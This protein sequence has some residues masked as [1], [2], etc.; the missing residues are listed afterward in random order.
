[1]SERRARL[2]FKE[3]FDICE[4]SLKPNFDKDEIMKRYGIGKSCLYNTLKQK[5]SIL[6]MNSSKNNANFK[7]FNT[8]K[9]DELETKLTHCKK[10]R[11]IS[12]K[13]KIYV[14]IP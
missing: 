8:S 14:H 6:K 13:K 11:H 1:M 4:L 9:N 12:L 3:K 10:E 2:S 5:E 7:R